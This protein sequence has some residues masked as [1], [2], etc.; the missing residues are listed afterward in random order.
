MWYC[1]DYWKLL[2]DVCWNSWRK[3]KKKKGDMS[4]T[5][6]RAVIAEDS[7]DLLGSEV[8]G[9]WEW[10]PDMGKSCPEGR[11][12]ILWC[13]MWG[14]HRG[15]PKRRSW[16]SKRKHLAI[17]VVVLS[18]TAMFALPGDRFRSIIDD[19]WWFGTVES[20]Q[21]FQA[22]YPDS[23]FQCYSVQW[24]FPCP[25]APAQLREVQN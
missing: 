24:V 14:W 23:S 1:K 11:G 13:K 7:P 12:S 2:F 16:F 21:P 15:I 4:E 9:S 19:A 17:L 3:E 6:P 5:V 10:F 20:Q 22:E 8:W 18:V 25:G